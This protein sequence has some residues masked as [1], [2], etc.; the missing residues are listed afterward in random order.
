M[1]DQIEPTHSFAEIADNV[2]NP[3]PGLTSLLEA[4]PIVLVILV[5]VGIGLIWL[6][7]RSG[8]DK[9]TGN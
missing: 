3:V 5:I 6:K 4:L 8:K 7:K 1:S 9:D 2:S